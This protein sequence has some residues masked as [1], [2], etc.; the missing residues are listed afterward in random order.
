MYKG[1][2]EFHELPPCC[3]IKGIN[4]NNPS[5]VTMRHCRRAV[6][7]NTVLTLWYKQGGGDNLNMKT[8]KIA[9]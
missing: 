6:I 4:H 8:E 1:G 7:C 5:V 3:A 9:S 2:S